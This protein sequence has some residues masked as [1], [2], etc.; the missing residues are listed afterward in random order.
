MFGTG[1]V[2]LVCRFWPAGSVLPV[3]S[4][5]SEFPLS[6]WNPL[7]SAVTGQIPSVVTKWMRQEASLHVKRPRD[8][9]TGIAEQR[10]VLFKCILKSIGYRDVV[11]Y[12]EFFCTT[13]V[14]G[15]A[16]STFL[17]IFVLGLHP[18]LHVWFLRLA[19]IAVMA[20]QRHDC[21]AGLAI[22]GNPSKSSFRH[23]DSSEV[24]YAS[25]CDCGGC[26]VGLCLLE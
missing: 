1:S 4:L 17:T 19:V 5:Q 21:E 11:W 18:G 9:E 3:N 13:V 15:S 12:R 14:C 2:T 24:S 26:T 20:M 16:V 8:V 25:F 23:N 10:V 22:P 6:R 7:E